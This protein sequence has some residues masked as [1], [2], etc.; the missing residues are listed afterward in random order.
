MVGFINAIIEPAKSDNPQLPIKIIIIF[1]K[2][3]ADR[4]SST[5]IATRYGLDGPGIESRCGGAKFSA[6]VQ[7]GP[8]AHPASYTIGV[9][10]PGRGVDHQPP[11]SAKV[12]E[13]VELYLYA[14]SGPSLA[15]YR[16]N[17]TFTFTF[18]CQSSAYGQPRNKRFQTVTV[19]GMRHIW[20]DTRRFRMSVYCVHLLILLGA[21]LEY[22]KSAK[23]STAGRKDKSIIP[24]TSDSAFPVT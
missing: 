17:F 15:C 12:K 5:G 18:L 10:R 23:T 9:K 7:T 6:P 8:R 4:D 16:A 2:S 1:V 20:I 13:R 21:K 22:S 19:E 24:A 14:P 11:S 3:S